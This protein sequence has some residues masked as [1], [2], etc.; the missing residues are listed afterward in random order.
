MA[1]IGHETILIVEDDAGVAA[2]EQRRLERAGYRV[3]SA[4]TAD[5]AMVQLRQQRIDLILLDYRLPENVDGLDFYAS[6]RAAGFDVPVIL[7]TGFSNEAT[8][9]KALRTGVRDF[10]TKSVEFLEYL[11]EAVGRVLREVR[12]EHQVAESEQRFRAMADHAPVFIFVRDP[13]GSLTFTNQTWLNFSGRNLEQ[14]LGGGWLNSIHP[15]DQDRCRN[16]IRVAVRDRLPYQ[17][18]FRVRR[19]DGEYR[20]LLSSG[21]PRFLSDGSHAGFVSVAIDI[22]ERKQA[23]ERIREQ[24]ALLDQARDAIMVHNLD[25]CIL[26]WNLGAERLYGWTAAEAIGQ[27]SATLLCRGHSPELEEA[28]RQVVEN[29]EWKGEL[30]Q[31]T[32]S[33]KE[34]IVESRRTLLRDAEQRPRAKL[35]INTD[36]TE[37]RKLEAQFQQAQKME[38]IGRLAGGV[39]HDFNNLLTVIRGFSEI[40]LTAHPLSPGARNLVLE[41]H[42][43]SERAADMTRQLL[44]FSRKQVLQPVVLDLNNVVRDLEKILRRLIGADIELACSLDP[45]IEKIQADP[46]QIEQVLMNLV[47][48]ARDAM[49][50]GGRLTME[51]QNA[52][53]DNA[54]AGTHADVKPGRYVLLAISDTGCGMDE[55]IKGRI[56]E[57]FFTTKEVGKGTGLGLATVYGIVKQSGGHIEVYSELGRGTTFKIYLPRAEETVLARDRMSSTFQPPHGKETIL[58]AED[59]DAVRALARMTLQPLGY[60][61][62]EAH[63]GRQALEIAQQHAAPIH[64][65]ITDVVMPELG[66]PQLV[67]KLRAQGRRLK[68]LYLSGYTDDAVVRHG[69]LSKGTAFLQKPFTTQALAQKVREVLDGGA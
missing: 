50:E 15:E 34:A 20:W 30:H 63:D 61:F 21:T 62:L 17:A 25:D 49:P 32:K 16:T 33:G 66:G 55:A 48:N 41:I 43:A 60:S 7:V 31:V 37:K 8:V 44:A 65:L 26:Y 27:Q 64:L 10:V 13:D 69:M 1:E 6:I 18:E 42:K 40:L 2:L 35:V 9:I 68:V 59:E 4:L 39:A 46:G 57:P 54:Y 58:L 29:G 56:F 53:L 28:N 5:A 38:S 19:A 51:T 22:T 45:A 14:N 36:I 12:M 24:A 3:V 67:E 11:P 47:V 23:E 52:K